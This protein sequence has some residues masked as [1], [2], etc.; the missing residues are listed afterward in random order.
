MIKTII[1][2]GNILFSPD[3]LYC[4]GSG[5]GVLAD[6]FAENLKRLRLSYEKPM[7]VTSCCRSKKHNNDIGGNPRSFHIY[8]DP[9]YPTGGTCAIDIKR[10]AD[11]ALL[12]RLISLATGQGWSIGIA[13]NFVHLDRRTDYT[14]LPR[15]IY[16][17]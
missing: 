1:D 5:D 3:E 9:Y 12:H 7:F 15:V 11:G 16:F 6:G 17:Y 10:P 8:D 13:D 4:K 2:N 14:D